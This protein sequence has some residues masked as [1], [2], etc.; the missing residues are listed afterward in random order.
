VPRWSYANTSRPRADLAPVN[1][2]A[3]A[4]N[5]VWP[6]ERMCSLVGRMFTVRRAARS[7]IVAEPVIPTKK[8]GSA[9]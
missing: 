1:S 5:V 9:E 7:F 2:G 3:V 4:A 6:W 8:G